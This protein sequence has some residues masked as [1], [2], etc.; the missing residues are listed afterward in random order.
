M[1]AKALEGVK[2]LEYC[3]LI[4][5][6]YCTKIMADMGAEVVKIEP[7]SEGD[8]ARKRP[9]FPDDSPH[10]EKS[11]LFLYLNTNK[12]GITLDPSK[13]KG[14][15]ILEE[16]V[17]EADV[18]VE[19]RPPGEMERLGLRYEHLKAL[20]PGLIMAS[21]TPFG[22]SGPY[23]N[24]KAYQLNLVHAS[25][26]GYLLPLPSPSLDR[27]PV[28]VGGNPGD[29]DPGLVGVVAILAALYWKGVTGQ[30]QFIELSKHE[31][32]ISMQ[33]VE[34]VTFPN[35]GVSMDRLG[36]VQGRMPGGIMPCK[37]GYVVSV[38][39]EEHQWRALMQLIG[40]PQWAEEE[41]CK[42]QQTRS[43]HASVL[44]ERIV[45]WMKEHTMEEIFKKGQ[46][47]SC[48]IAPLRS[49]KDVVESAQLNARGFFTEMEHP[50]AGKLTIPTAPYRSSKTPWRLE[51]PAPLLGQHNEEIYCGR[52][53]HSKQQL[54]NLKSCGVI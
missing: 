31:A 29:Y 12:L 35:D 32:L 6:P 26:Q 4:S 10:R 37:D 16:L 33:R 48:P 38:T 40:N 20:N 17:K 18:L 42:D 41:W 44:T 11:G 22:R 1:Q 46:A 19:D 2:V 25:G 52:L 51:R 21:I 3:Q 54:A 7:P 27:P 49:A 45:S 28:K 13:E 39:P 43:R 34:S 36:G 24:Y 47:L 5:G 8:Q 50:E 53:G 14:K 30:G 23:R 15:A 9:P